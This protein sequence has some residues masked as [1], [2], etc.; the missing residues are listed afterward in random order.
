MPMVF[1]QIILIHKINHVLFFLVLM[2]I[3]R[4]RTRKI[5]RDTS[6]IIFNSFICKFTLTPNKI[7][8]KTIKIYLTE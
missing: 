1:D 3:F 5:N 7:Q 6:Y 4:L 8:I 2:S